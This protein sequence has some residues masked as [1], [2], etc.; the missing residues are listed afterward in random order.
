MRLARK[1]KLDEVLQCK[2]IG[3]NRDWQLESF[4][5]EA[6]WAGCGEQAGLQAVSV[7]WMTILVC[8]ANDPP[9]YAICRDC[10]EMKCV[11][12]GDRLNVKMIACKCDTQDVD[13]ACASK[14]KAKEP[15]T[16]AKRTRGF[17]QDLD[18]TCQGLYDTYTRKIG[19][20]E[21]RYPE[22]EPKDIIK[23]LLGKDASIDDPLPNG[24]QSNVPGVTGEQGGRLLACYLFKLQRDVEQ[25]GDEE[26]VLGDDADAQ[27]WLERAK[28][29][30]LLRPAAKLYIDKA[31]AF[32]PKLKIG[33]A[34]SLST[35]V[36]RR[37]PMAMTISR[38]SLATNRRPCEAGSWAVGLGCEV[39]RR[40]GG[41]ARRRGEW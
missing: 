15:Q 23:K 34:C 20:V 36:R 22:T 1:A 7:K 18:P 8:A 30:V 3:G 40:V 13:E 24:R 9:L 32:L 37:R 2:R 16:E 39:G 17:D 29:R 38:T 28:S 6:V 10:G 14:R 41:E 25:G 19:Q 27:A 33:L 21:S 4:I 12:K 35:R 26:G 5:E 31:I 11:H